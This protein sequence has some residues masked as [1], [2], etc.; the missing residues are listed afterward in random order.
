[1]IA[2]VPKAAS[3]SSAPRSTAPAPTAARS[4]RYVT[5]AFQVKIPVET[6]ATLLGPEENTLAIMKARL[7]AMSPVYRW[8]PVVQRYID[9]VSGRVNGLG[10]NAGSVAPSLNGTPLK[11]TEGGQCPSHGHEG[12]HHPEHRYRGKISGLIFDRFGDFEG[13]LLDTE[14]GV[15]KFLSRE[16]GVKKLAERAWQERLLVTV[17]AERDGCHHRLMKII[18]LEPPTFFG[19]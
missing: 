12:D 3:G 13:L 7:L 9:Y 18:I 2:E 16:L 10:G 17:L 8:Y 19:P 1:V 11:G 5:G 15:Y 6:A 14:S 4:W